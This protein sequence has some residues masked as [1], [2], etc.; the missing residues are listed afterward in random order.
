M[1]QHDPSWWA[2][3]SILAATSLFVL[4]VPVS[5]HGPP[6]MRLLYRTFAALTLDCV[7]KYPILSQ[8]L[9]VTTQEVAAITTA[10]LKLKGDDQGAV[11]NHVKSIGKTQAL[12]RHE[13][14]LSLGHML[15]D[16]V[17]TRLLVNSLVCARMCGDLP[18]RSG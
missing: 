2:E 9:Q 12:P 3:S 17:H 13:K 18:C 11:V 16:N 5:T 1:L 10:A 7:H 6:T 4:L 14:L 15:T 8:L